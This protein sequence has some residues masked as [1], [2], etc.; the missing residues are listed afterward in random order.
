MV[1]CGFKKPTMGAAYV[2]QPGAST[3]MWKASCQLLGKYPE[4][5]LSQSTQAL[6]PQ[7]LIQ[8][9]AITLDIDVDLQR[10][11]LVG[12]AGTLAV[13]ALKTFVQGVLA[14]RTMFDF[15]ALVS[16]N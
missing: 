6:F 11:S 1:A 10:A 12:A 8:Y 16:S 3:A 13:P 4:V 7:N 2:Q 5:T 14:S 15:H 9:F